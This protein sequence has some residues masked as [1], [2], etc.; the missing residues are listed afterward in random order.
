MKL[1]D[2]VEELNERG[3]ERQAVLLQ[4]K[5]KYS[6][7]LALMQKRWRSS[8]ESQIGT[9]LY[10]A[11]MNSDLCQSLLSSSNR[12]HS[13]GKNIFDNEKKPSR[14][15]QV[16]LLEVSIT[17]NFSIEC[18]VASEQIETNMIQLLDQAD[19][20]IYAE[21]KELT[22]DNDD[23]LL[24]IYRDEDVIVNEA[25]LS[26]Q[27][28][29]Q[30]SASIIKSYSK[31]ISE[32]RALGLPH[33]VMLVHIKP[34]QEYLPLNPFDSNDA[35]PGNVEKIC[36]YA[37]QVLSDEDLH[38]Q[39]IS[40]RS[41]LLLEQ[42]DTRVISNAKINITEALRE[43]YEY[44][45]DGHLSYDYIDM[46]VSSSDSNV[47]GVNQTNYH[48]KLLKTDLKFRE[49]ILRNFQDEI[50]IKQRSLMGIKQIIAGSQATNSHVG[51]F[52]TKQNDGRFPNLQYSKASKDALQQIADEMDQLFDKLP[53]IG[54]LAVPRK[55]R[56]RGT[57]SYMV[58][59]LD[60]D[61][62]D[63]T[64]GNEAGCCIFV[65]K[66]KS[67]IQNGYSVPVYL[68]EKQI[69]LFGVYRLDGEKK[70]SYG[71]SFGI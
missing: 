54:D 51:E 43:L 68:L 66:E 40:R 55:L 39:N 27:K 49:D 20:I 35:S 29:M 36:D 21:V 19:K 10:Q 17:Q 53:D 71:F 67:K 30:N 58:E 41:E 46:M 31:R 11:L 42:H 57:L 52:S 23:L 44:G 1:T 63:V 6:Y 61:P 64:F 2:I 14:D 24:R 13:A 4:S 70:T 50:R 22:A 16:P 7:T 56:N 9:D 18:L 59:E 45:I 28:K 60:Y 69:K 12:D 33:S 38:R 5:F 47:T 25:N 15:F 3:F 65:P 48:Q 26:D 8:V 34:L 62:M 32:V 37:N